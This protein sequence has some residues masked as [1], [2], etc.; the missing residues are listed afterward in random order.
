M[1]GVAGMGSDQVRVI[2][3]YL[4]FGALGVVEK[5][6][7]VDGDDPSRAGGR[8]QQGMGRM[9]HIERLPDDPFNGRPP[10]GMPAVV[11]R[12]HRNLPV[13]GVDAGG[14][15]DPAYLSTSY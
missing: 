4:S 6:Q 14:L 1:V 10:E 12:P 13:H 5:I 15:L 7:V 3:P 2:S 9:H 11:Q 8:D